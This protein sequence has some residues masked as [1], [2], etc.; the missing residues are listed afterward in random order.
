MYRKRRNVVKEEKDNVVAF[1][2]FKIELFQLTYISDCGDQD[3]PTAVWSPLI[4]RTAQNTLFNSV[5]DFISEIMVF[6][7]I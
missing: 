6:T 2:C 3:L 7:E 1:K 4:L 5:D